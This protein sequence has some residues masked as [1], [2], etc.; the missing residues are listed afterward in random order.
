MAF[1]LS[2][3]TFY[4]SHSFYK[5][6]YHDGA[7]EALDDRKKILFIDYVRKMCKELNLQYIMTLIDSDLPKDKSNKIVA[8]TD[9]EI[10]LTL[11]DK[12]DSGKLFK[13]SF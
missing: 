2:I 12:D 11:H 5:F 1:D 9:E 8:F 4:S 7:L 13:R 3:M 10:T 6:V